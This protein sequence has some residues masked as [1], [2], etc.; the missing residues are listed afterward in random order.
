MKPNFD[1]PMA[2]NL[3]GYLN[4]VRLNKIVDATL[5]ISW[6]QKTQETKN[7]TVGDLMQFIGH[8]IVSIQEALFL[9]RRHDLDLVELGMCTPFQ[10]ATVIVLDCYS[11]ED[12]VL[13]PLHTV[14]G[15]SLHER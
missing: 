2:T 13:L 14:H 10:C 1:A 3:N 5:R 11:S 4:Q 7:P 15:D 9:A 6:M 8:R 12:L